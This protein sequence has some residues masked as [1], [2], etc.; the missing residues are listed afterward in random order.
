M[1]RTYAQLLAGIV[2]DLRR[3]GLDSIISDYCQSVIEDFQREYMY[4]SPTTDLSLTL[5]PNQPTYP[6]PSYIVGI[7][8][9]RLLRSDTWN[10]VDERRYDDILNEDTQSP[11]IISQPYHWAR[12]GRVFRFYPTPDDEYPVEITGTGK[13]PAPAVSADVNWWTEDARMYVRHETVHRI[14][15]NVLRDPEGAR[16]AERLALVAR[17]GLL[18]EGIAKECTGRLAPNW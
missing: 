14:R 10:D 1:S 3:P 16:S 15:D 13:I 9:I 18:S 7:E 2:A 12:Y 17:D 8:R 6:V 4:E 11:P 5:I